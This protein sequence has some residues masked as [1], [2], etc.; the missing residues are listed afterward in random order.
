MM[1]RGVG[2]KIVKSEAG[3]GPL[4]GRGSEWEEAGNNKQNNTTTKEKVVVKHG[5]LNRHPPWLSNALKPHHHAPIA[6]CMRPRRRE[7][8]AR[9][10]YAASS[11][12]SSA[13]RRDEGHEAPA[14]TCER[15]AH[16][17][18]SKPLL[19]NIWHQKLF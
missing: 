6:L 15:R 8:K 3:Q 11:L 17:C 5:V 16:R 13:G 4:I 12:G 19:S 9:R 10:R 18:S 7:A 14:H 1:R 2:K